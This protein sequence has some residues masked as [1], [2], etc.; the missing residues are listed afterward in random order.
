MDEKMTYL[1]QHKRAFG[2]IK[3]YTKD[4]SYHYVTKTMFTALVRPIL[5]YASIPFVRIRLD[6]ICE[7]NIKGIEIVWS[8]WYYL[9]DMPCRLFLSQ[10]KCAGKH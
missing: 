9:M 7:Y 6:T 5:E 1:A 10:K 3:R 4:Y 2:I 8:R